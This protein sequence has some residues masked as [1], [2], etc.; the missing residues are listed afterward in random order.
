MGGSLKEKIFSDTNIVRRAMSILSYAGLGAGEIHR[1]AWDS[2]RP[3]P[4]QLPGTTDSRGLS[5]E[6]AKALLDSV[7]VAGNLRDQVLVEMGLVCGL[8]QVELRRI[9]LGDIHPRDGRL[10]ISVQGK[11]G[12]RREIYVPQ[13]LQER[14]ERLA[15]GEG[16]HLK[17]T[18]TVGK[19]HVSRPLFQSPTGSA[20]SERGVRY[21]IDRHLKAVAPEASAHGLRHTCVTWLLNTGATLEQA[22]EIVG[23]SEASS[24]EIY[25]AV[26]ESW[27]VRTWQETHPIAQWGKSGVGHVYVAGEPYTRRMSRNTERVVPLPM[28]LVR[29]VLHSFNEG[30]LPGKIMSQKMLSWIYKDLEYN[31][32]VL[33]Q[34]G[35]IHMAENGAHPFTISLILGV[36][37]GHVIDSKFHRRGKKAEDERVGAVERAVARLYQDTSVDAKFRLA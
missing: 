29:E 12:G 2:V 27:F 26:D 13:P 31:P 1:L 20:V 15:A 22:M 32:S 23:H 4:P 10:F 35:A 25:A 36:T 21:L 3:T 30:G 24:H 5:Y 16:S 37:P 6:Q 28:D 34:M 11:G 9:R 8:R 33:R 7:A 17:R 19:R 14:V 18:S